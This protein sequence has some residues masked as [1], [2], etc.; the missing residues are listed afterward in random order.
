MTN[1]NNNIFP[2]EF[3]KK[4][5][6]LSGFFRQVEDKDLNQES[7]VPNDSQV[8]PMRIHIPHKPVA[9][10]LTRKVQLTP[11]DLPAHVKAISAPIPSE[12]EPKPIAAQNRRKLHSLHIPHAPSPSEVADQSTRILKEAAPVVEQ[13]SPSRPVAEVHP[14]KTTKA[15]SSSLEPILTSI[16]KAETARSESIP[17]NTQMS[18]VVK[19]KLAKPIDM[20]FPI[21]PI[22]KTKAASAIDIPRMVP[23]KKAKRANLSP[24]LLP[25][26]AKRTAEHIVLET[27]KQSKGTKTA[28]TL[29]IPYVSKRKETKPKKVSA[30]LHVTKI[31]KRARKTAPVQTAKALD[32]ISSIAPLEPPKKLASHFDVAQSRHISPETAKVAVLNVPHL[33]KSQIVKSAKSSES[34]RIPK[35]GKKSFKK[36]VPLH[37]ADPSLS[38]P[39]LVRQNTFA[40]P[41]I[42]QA[43]QQAIASPQS[44]QTEIN[45]SVKQA[46]KIA[47]TKKL[48]ESIDHLHRHASRFKNITLRLPKL[49][50][51]KKRQYVVKPKKVRTKKSGIVGEVVRFGVTSA[52]IFAFSFVIMNGPA[53][54]QMVQARLDPVQTVHKQIALEKI[55]SGQTRHVPI[56][57]TAGMKRESRE[58]YPGLDLQIAPLENR[59]I[60]P[61]IGKN[62]PLVNIETDSLQRS[63]WEQLEQDIQDALQDGVVHYPGTAK[64][65]QIGNVF[66]TGHS[67]YYLWDPGK[68][69][70]VF[71]RLHDMYEG[72]EFTIYWNQDVYHYRIRERKVVSPEETSVLEQPKDERIATLMTCTPIGTA[73]D[74]LILVAE[75][76]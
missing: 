42:R 13:E 9:Y 58:T 5:S 67:S 72:D 24:I 64:P 6:S 70:D 4:K 55:V 7:V 68:F 28:E 16:P 65:G 47:P 3:F 18:P 60:L 53:I 34:L 51:R 35:A 19:T 2:D 38:K 54:G 29:I 50:K 43:V 62:V 39:L 26:V 8:K 59:I 33:K 20:V 48:A 21:P 76:I 63:D 40:A 25:Q 23:A 12:A 57:P 31:G 46:T 36:Q 71:A 56:L 10:R 74:R 49:P 15:A 44:I 73:K 37:I 66:V 27:P 1:K 17:V 14:I 75:Q 69:K 41:E 11:P 52:L 30:L 61:K 22:A 32:V 45:S